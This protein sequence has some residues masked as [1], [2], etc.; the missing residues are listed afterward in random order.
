M[1]GV[2]WDSGTGTVDNRENKQ[3][4]GEDT[5]PVNLGDPQ[6]PVFQQYSLPLVSSSTN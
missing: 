1:P 3:Q 2:F 4:S 5:C 6:S